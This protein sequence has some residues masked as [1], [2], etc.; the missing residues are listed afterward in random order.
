ML[1]VHA[2][3][4]SAPRTL[5]SQA[6]AGERTSGAARPG[7]KLHEALAAKVKHEPKAKR[8]TKSKS[9]PVMGAALTRP[10]EAAKPKPKHKP[11]PRAKVKTLD[12]F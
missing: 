9:K 7:S 2:F 6:R 4:F 5:R 10:A 1:I 12:L 8:T 11:K 3:L